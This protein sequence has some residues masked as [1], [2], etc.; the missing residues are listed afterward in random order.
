LKLQCA[1]LST[2]D[3]CTRLQAMVPCGTNS[4]HSS[5]YKHRSVGERRGYRQ[6]QPVCGHW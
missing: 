2:S 4:F 5:T 3:I 1:P 6:Q